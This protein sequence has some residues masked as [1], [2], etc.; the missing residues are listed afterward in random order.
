MHLKV[1]IQLKRKPVMAALASEETTTRIESAAKDVVRWSISVEDSRT[2]STY[3]SHLPWSMFT[4][5]TVTLYSYEMSLTRFS[6]ERWV[7][8]CDICGSQVAHS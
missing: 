3:T 6:S 5:C 4:L 1:I 2:I 8:R 7:P